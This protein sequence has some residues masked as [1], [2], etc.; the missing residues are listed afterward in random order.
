MRFGRIVPL[1]MAALGVALAATSPAGAGDNSKAAET[2]KYGGTLVYM[3]PAD[4]LP[5][6]DAHREAT[7]AVIHCYRPVL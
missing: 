1:A 6:F 7:Y 4:S 3:I 5:S 2:P